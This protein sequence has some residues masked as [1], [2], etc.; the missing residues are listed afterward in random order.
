MDITVAMER[1]GY[2]VKRRHRTKSKVG[3]RHSLTPYEAVSFIKNE[4]DVEIT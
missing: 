1:L 4:F 3:S 2:R